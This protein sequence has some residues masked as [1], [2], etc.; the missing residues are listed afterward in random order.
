MID[1]ERAELKKIKRANAEWWI[2]ERAIVGDNGLTY[3]AYVNDM[4][5]VHVKELDAKCSKTPSRDFRLCKLNC[6]YSD[7]H[8]APGMCI[9]N[10]GRI[11]VAYTGHAAN[12]SL[13]Y[14][15][16]EKPYDIYSFG[17]EQTI[18]FDGTVTY[19]QV[20]ENSARNE[21]WIFCRVDKVN[22]EFVCSKDEGETW[23][24]PRRFLHSD[25]G[26]LFYFN[27]R[28]Q[29]V[30]PKNGGEQWFFALYGHPR[31]SADHTIRSGLFDAN[32]QLLKTDKTP[33]DLN[34]FEGDNLINLPD[35][36]VV[37][38]SPE[39]TTVRLLANAATVP[40][41]I[42]FAPFVNEEPD[43]IVYHT[44]T[45]VDGAWKISEPICSGGE[46][47]SP[48]EL[49]AQGLRDGSQTYVGGM[50][51]YYG[52]GEAG[53]NTK[54]RTFASTETNRVYIARFDGEARVLESYLSRDCG[55]TYKLEQVIR[56]I[57]KE[58]DIKIWRPVVPIHAQ[59][60]MPVYWHE[61]T[62]V[63]HTGGWHSDAVMAIE[64]DD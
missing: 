9:L 47:L 40:L 43:T 56:R 21:I 14:R 12:G 57:P 27:I 60:N 55:A 51:Y 28:K 35:L 64:Y 38:A 58:E 18:S 36:D 13:R 52:V 22:W 8:N 5:E 6:N 1:F 32:G 49:A 29:Y 24:A 48:M 33:M 20:S 7:E 17:P 46:F 63:L 19:A 41:R 53:M 25:D 26:G 31:G 50:E 4:G 10:S 11:L 34:L 62:Y 23:E 15:I 30:R 16:T 2:H 61:G 45:F 59:D 42:G 37:Y 44:A 39:G 3:I 54:A